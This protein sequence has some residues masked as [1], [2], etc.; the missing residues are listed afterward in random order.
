MQMGTSLENCWNL[1]NSS[2]VKN[3][4]RFALNIYDLIRFVAR[5]RSK[6]T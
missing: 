3:T 1:L 4:W 5:K 6:N 2:A